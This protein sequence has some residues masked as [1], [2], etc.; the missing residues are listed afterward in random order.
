M[1]LHDPDTNKGTAL[2]RICKDLNINTK[3][4]VVFGDGEN[5]VRSAKDDILVHHADVAITQVAMFRTAGFSVAMGNAMQAAKD[6]AT[7]Q[8][9]SNDEGG[10][11]HFLDRVFR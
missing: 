3:N 4:C 9:V 2:T 8:T 5:D 7:H 11:G 1:E 6:A 10:V